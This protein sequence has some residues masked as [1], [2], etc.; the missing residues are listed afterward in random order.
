MALLLSARPAA[1]RQGLERSERHLRRARGAAHRGA[2]FLEFSPHRI[3]AR[4]T[5]KPARGSR[6]RTKNPRAGDLG[7]G[8]NAWH[9]QLLFPPSRYCTSDTEPRSEASTCATG[10]AHP[11]AGVHGMCGYNA[12]KIA[13]RDLLVDARPLRGS[14]SASSSGITKRSLTSR[15]EKPFA[16]R[17]LGFEKTRLMGHRLHVLLALASL[18]VACRGQDDQATHPCLRRSPPR[19][20][21]RLCSSPL[22]PAEKPRER[23]RLPS[24]K[25][26]G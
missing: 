9:N 21:S 18:I 1:R 19:R 2:Q 26:S 16:S 22:A 13:Y 6:P 23:A 3:L 4:S 17:V 5:K 11:G 8:T 24:R 10:Y 20:P 15:A 14:R 12:A 7:G 25:R